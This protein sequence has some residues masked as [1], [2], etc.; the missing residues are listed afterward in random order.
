MRNTLTL[1]FIVLITIA[2]TYALAHFMKMD[3]FAFA[4]ALNF[5]LMGCVMSFTEN[6]KDGFNSGYYNEQPWEKGGKLYRAL[7]I[8]IYRKLLVLI[9]WEKL[10]KKAAPVER[11]TDALVHLHHRTKKSELG[12]L[13]IFII[14]AGFNVYVAN[15]FGF[16]KSLSLLIT[17]IFL[18]LYPILLQRY[19]R[20]RIARA[21]GISKQRAG[22]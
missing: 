10:N 19:N 4:W 16:A 22:F 8:N 5:L 6:V 7:G 21:I 14:V 13:I 11:K 17:N 15:Q 20:P 3:T 18:N 1:I 9:G 2:L 12:H